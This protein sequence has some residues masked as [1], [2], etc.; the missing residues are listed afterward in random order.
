MQHI[1]TPKTDAAATLPIDLNSAISIETNTDIASEKS[2]FVFAN[3][4]SEAGDQTQNSGDRII[5]RGRITPVE[6]E[7]ETDSF[8][9]ATTNT[10][11]HAEEVDVDWVAFVDDVIAGDENNDNATEQAVQ[12]NENN[13]LSIVSSEI[14]GELAEDAE[15]H[16]VVVEETDSALVIEEDVV[17]ELLLSSLITE[18]EISANNL[19][20]EGA[21]SNK[22]ADEDIEI[23]IEQDGLIDN[24]DYLLVEDE[25]SLLDATP[26]FKDNSD[27]STVDNTENIDLLFEDTSSNNVTLDNES[28]DLIAQD[29]VLLTTASNIVSIINA[30]D[31]SNDSGDLDD[32]LRLD[33]N[34]EIIID[35][36]LTAE[37]Q[38]ADIELVTTLLESELEEISEEANIASDNSSTAAVTLPS[39]LNPDENKLIDSEL[40]SLSEDDIEAVIQNVL[41]VLPESVDKANLALTLRADI[42][43]S[44][45]DVKALVNNG[46]S[47]EESLASIV[48]ESLSGDAVELTD[49]QQS[50]VLQQA[51]KTEQFLGLVQNIVEQANGQLNVVAQLLSSAAPTS[52]AT[53]VSLAT[54]FDNLTAER[55]I[56]VA[57]QN[58]VQTQAQ[59]STDLNRPVA[60]HQVEGQKQVAEKIRWMVGGRVTAAEIRLDPPELGSM[61]IRINMVG[62]TAS[63]NFV[64]QSAQARDVLAQ[65][66]SQLKDMLAE[67]GLDLGESFVSTQDGDSSD[68]E[69]AEGAAN[70]PLF[71]SESDDDINV[72]EQPI[73]PNQSP[74]NVDAYV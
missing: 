39:A 45:S 40:A 60:I 38:E 21:E 53:D 23:Q 43:A 14:E 36:L 16:I 54:T 7:P 67:Q 19:T 35:P 48:E 57:A 59:T 73:R 41:T 30:I 65:T 70:N 56:D 49:D 55:A 66:E 72:I 58:R 3:L 17:E 42:V 28:A 9:H 5:D 50:L 29:D 62:E 12:G 52:H 69:S 10:D 51:A 11:E 26:I 71:A 27:E 18:N 25:E 37:Q 34:A 31:G 13:V 20:V 64:V 22:L 46:Q 63:V 15:G 24:L 44:V 32:G 2:E 1:A 74:Y 6:P 61:Q 68:G 8:A 47:S 4:L 33:T